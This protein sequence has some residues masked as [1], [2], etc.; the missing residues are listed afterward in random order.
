MRGILVCFDLVVP[1]STV[2]S[3]LFAICT[4]QA[5]PSLEKTYLYDDRR[6][7]CFDRFVVSILDVLFVDRGYL[8][9]FMLSFLLCDL[10]G[11]GTERTFNFSVDYLVLCTGTA[12]PVILTTC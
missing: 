11:R 2:A 1:Q 5:V 6:V 3:V 8:R 9:I 12:V 7:W 10:L 4:H